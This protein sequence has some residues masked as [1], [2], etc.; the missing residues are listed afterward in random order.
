[1]V[2][3][4]SSALSLVN[5]ACCHHHRRDAMSIVANL[6]PASGRQDHTASPSAM[7]PLVWRRHPRP[8]HPA[9]TFVTIAKRP[10]WSGR[11]REEEPLICPSAQGQFFRIKTGRP[12]QLERIFEFAFL[13]QL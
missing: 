9:P 8:S 10:S 2:L 13:A 11:T 12:N 4:V 1:M 3:T 6:T 7:T 5:R